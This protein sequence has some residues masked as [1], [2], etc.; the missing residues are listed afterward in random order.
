MAVRGRVLCTGGRDGLRKLV[1][2]VHASTAAELAE[3]VGRVGLWEFE[4]YRA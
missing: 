2:N 1:G 3:K 4:D